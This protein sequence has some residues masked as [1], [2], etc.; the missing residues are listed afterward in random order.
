MAR[1]NQVGQLDPS[2]TYTPVEVCHQSVLGIPITAFET[3]GLLTRLKSILQ[4]GR[5]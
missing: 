2:S 3:Y 4:D 1:V 5:K